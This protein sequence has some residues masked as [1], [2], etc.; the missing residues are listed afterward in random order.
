MK[1]YIITACVMFISIMTIQAQ[2][3]I[4]GVCGDGVKW[5]FDGNTLN[6]T[7]V[8]EG[9]FVPMNNYNM[10]KNISPWL[11]KKL[12]IKRVVVG[13][14]VTS[15]GSC[16]FAGCEN[17]TEVIFD[18]AKV[19]TIGWGAFLN[20]KNLHLISLPATLQEIGH[21]A[22]ANCR[23]LNRVIIPAKCHVEDQAF[24]SCDNLQSIDCEPTAVL[25]QLV[26]VKEQK[27]DGKVQHS[28]YSG[29]IIRIPPYVN[30]GNCHV[31][32]LSKK[33]VEKATKDRIAKEDYDKATS[34]LDKNIPSTGI[35]RNNTYVLI[36]G[37]QNYRFATDVT[38]AIHDAR[39]FRNYCNKTLGIPSLNIHVAEDATKQM[40][41]EEE[42]EDWLGS[43]QDRENKRL[44]VYY[45]GHGVPDTRNG[46]KSYL[47][48][49]DVRGENPKHAIAL[50]DF[51]KQIGN[52][53][54]AQTS[55]FLD[56]CFSGVNRNNDGVTENIRSV[57]IDV[58]DTPLSEGKLIVF[59][60][61]QGNE[62]AQGYPEQGHGLFTYYLLDELRNSQGEI[63]F[64]T[65]SDNITDKVRNTAP[66]LKM[67]KKQTPITSVSEAL[68]DEW[69]QLGF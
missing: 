60:A 13:K 22:F 66:S 40:I 3:A 57:A 68:E 8:Q 53:D 5:M 37:N 59:S 21:V 43:I 7:A 61:A 11:K 33:A 4:E 12:D 1:K 39:V 16:A 34:D 10:K 31:Y 28:L 45:A 25:G 9:V 63:K 56:A 30:T 51:Y 62:T 14:G 38:Y 67:H 58:E 36:I 52:L 17:L 27:V 29:D 26:F 48:P 69:R 41:L 2:T 64:G 47:L 20:C 6:I 18:G 44:I 35:T 55:V 19:G 24:A 65:L 49:T 42:L 50:D 46:N 23:S 32:G 54:F 15:I